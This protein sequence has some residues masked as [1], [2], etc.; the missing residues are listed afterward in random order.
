MKTYLIILVSVI[1]LLAAC[2]PT[3]T[4]QETGT[5]MNEMKPLDHI[6]CQEREI[7]EQ[8]NCLPAQE[9]NRALFG[10]DFSNK[11]SE[12]EINTEELQGYIA[13]PVAPGNYPGLLVI[14]EW[15]GLNDNI[16]EMAQLL[17]NEGYIVFAIDLYEG[18][19]AQD[20]TAAREYATN[21]RSNPEEAI[22]HMQR[23]ITYLESQGA[24]K[25]GSLGWCFGGQQSLQISLNEELDATVIYY[26]N[27]VEDPEQLK[28]LQGP[29]LGIFGAEDGSIPVESVQ[30]FET[31]LNEVGVQNQIHI[32]DGVG[33][34]F[35][36]P[37][38]SNYAPDETIDAWEKTVAFLAENLQG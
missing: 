35:A 1:L 34:A 7:D 21:V 10:Q 23:A 2:Q 17:A 20:S 3:A 9:N 38:G 27:L 12:E 5:D 33:H 29:V 32:Y 15:W 19:V 25:V 4:T 8:G 14:H 28:Q 18:N 16:K 36:N 26:G 13:R 30:S 37:S 11:V 6:G 31:G 24:T 22:A